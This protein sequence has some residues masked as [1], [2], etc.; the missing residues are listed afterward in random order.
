[1]KTKLFGLSILLMGLGA[2]P[3]AYA[4]SQCGVP[5]L[6]VCP[7]PADEKLPDVKNMLKW[8]MEDRMIGFRNDYRAYPGDVFKHATPRP[9]MRQ[10][11]D[12]SS[13]SYTVD[14]HSYNLQEYVARNKIAGLMVIKNG[15][16]VLEFYGRGNTPRTLWTSRSVGKSVV[17]TLVGVALKEGKIKSLDDKVVRYNPD[18]KG[19]V[20]ANITI[21]ELLQHTSGVKWDENYEDDNSDFAKLTQCE[22]LDNAYTCVHD[23]V[24]N[25]KRVK[26]AEPGKVWAYSSGGAWLLGDTLEKAVKMP[27]AQYLQEK[28]WKPYGMVS[29]GVWHSYQKGKHD[30]GAHGFNATLEDWGKFGQFV[31]YNGFL[32]D[33][34]TILPDHW[35]VDARTWNKATNSVNKNHPEGSYGFEW[36]NNAV[37]QST[38]NVS[39]KLGLSSSETM[40]GLGIYGQ[41]LVVNQQE[42]MV[43]VQW[44]T[45]EKAEPSFSAEPLEASLM[46]NAISNS[47]NQ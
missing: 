27:L 17:S 8:N 29:D 11:H 31:L 5:E 28:I 40:W 41:M 21:R 6:T 7:T 36:W 26:Q 43:I 33:G 9:L 44:S 32:P 19:T 24:I 37:P 13:V 1:M 45:W 10:I 20:W 39:P 25:K 34:K 42:N 12:M 46:F 38:E 16:V 35:V 18:V 14:G 47:L 30:T 2:F 15:V 22:A 3:N 4:N 23:L